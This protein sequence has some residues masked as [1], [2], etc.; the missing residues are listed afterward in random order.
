MDKVIKETLRLFPPSSQT[1]RRTIKPVEFDGFTIPEN[2]YVRLSMDFIHQMPEYWHQP[3]QFDPERFADNRAEHKKHPF[4]YIP[5]GGGA[6]KCIG[7]H[8]ADFEVKTVLFHLL[9]NYRIEIEPGYEVKYHYLPVP[10]PIDNLPLKL[11]K[12]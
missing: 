10:K 3:D 6:H 8:F 1:F 7:M 4:Q 5:F 12:R 2:T 9:K 11:I